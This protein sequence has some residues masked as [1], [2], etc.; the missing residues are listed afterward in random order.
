M[1]SLSSFVIHLI[2][3]EVQN[4][5]DETHLLKIGGLRIRSSAPMEVG[6]LPIIPDDNVS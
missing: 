1:S 6:V 5:K 4:P 3:K 2:R